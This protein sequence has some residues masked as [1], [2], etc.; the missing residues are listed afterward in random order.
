MYEV[1]QQGARSGPFDCGSINGCISSS[2]TTAGSNSQSKS[3]KGDVGSVATG[4]LPSSLREDRPP[5]EDSSTADRPAVMD[6][7]AGEKHMQE[8]LQESSSSVSNSLAQALQLPQ[9][10]YSHQVYVCYK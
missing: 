7:A 9:M 10:G 2:S 4:S 1:G 5:L 3:K 6:Q 8:Q